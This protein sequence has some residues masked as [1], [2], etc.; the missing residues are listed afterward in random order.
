MK[1]EECTDEIDYHTI[2]NDKDVYLC[3]GEDH[4]FNDAERNEPIICEMCSR[5]KQGYWRNDESDLE[6][7]CYNC[8]NF[9]DELEDE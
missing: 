6:I 5:Q 3:S 1:K 4:A 2:L 9:E 8:Y 7:V